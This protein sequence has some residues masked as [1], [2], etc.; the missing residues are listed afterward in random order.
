MIF[1][2]VNKKILMANKRL[3]KNSFLFIMMVGTLYFF[4]KPGMDK[5]KAFN[6]PD[7]IL[8]TPKAQ[9]NHNRPTIV[10]NAAVKKPLFDKSFSNV[11][12]ANHL[13]IPNIIH[14]VRFNNAEYSFVEY[15]CLRAAFRN[16]RPDFIYIHTD[17]DEFTGKYWSW[18]KNEPELWTRIRIIPTE[19]PMEVFG[20]ELSTEWRFFH[21]SDFVRLHAIQKFGGIYLDNDV[22]VIKSLDKYD[23][24]S[25]EIFKRIFKAT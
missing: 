24:L 25:F 3:L 4:F 10:V 11:T 12:G 18:V 7:A 2:A 6:Y 21:G 9:E 8:M 1:F 22:F 15:V 17:V 13:I 16:Q 19:C 14:Y 5:H 23:L 20:Q